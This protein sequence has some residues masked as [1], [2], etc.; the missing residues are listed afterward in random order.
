M[1]NVVNKNDLFLFNGTS[2]EMGTNSEAQAQEDKNLWSGVIPKA[3][4]YDMAVFS[5][6]MQFEEMSKEEKAAKISAIK[7]S[8]QTI[9]SI[10]KKTN[11]GV[12]I[13]ISESELKDKSLGE[14]E[15]E[16]NKINNEI[17]DWKEVLEKYENDQKEL[18]NEQD[19]AQKDKDTKEK[20]YT[21]DVS[22]MTASQKKLKTLTK[23]YEKTEDRLED[24]N[25]TIA[26][27]QKSEEEAAKERIDSTVQRAKEDYDPEK[28]GQNFNQYLSSA[29]NSANVKGTNSLENLNK[30]AQTLQNRAFGLSNVI[31]KQAVTVDKAVEKANTSQKAFIASKTSLAEAQMRVNQNT[32]TINSISAQIGQAEQQ[33]VTIEKNIK[34]KKQAEAVEQGSTAPTQTQISDASQAA[35]DKSQ[36]NFLNLTLSKILSEA[37]KKT[38]LD[39]NRERQDEFIE[40][41]AQSVN[42]TAVEARKGSVDY[43]TLINKAINET[44]TP[45]PKEK[46][47]EK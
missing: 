2:S 44:S 4:T 10:S 11:S 31:D 17:Q 14:L 15:T 35:S 21:A 46:D 36:T 20:T 24:L 12:S 8:A 19:A 28:H 29:I 38:E 25:K 34:I 32:E 37:A 43:E 16:L 47:K 42:L 45:P 27:T 22:A 5:K 1:L 6:S 39:M 3:Q 18:L 33:K 23:S 40:Y 9:N 7:N 13:N 41:S 26:S 30:T